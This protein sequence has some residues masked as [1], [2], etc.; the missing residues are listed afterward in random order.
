MPFKVGDRV[1]KIR[2]NKDDAVKLHQTAIVIPDYQGHYSFC[3]EY[4][5]PSGQNDWVRA[6]PSKFVL[7]EVYNS[8]LYK[9]L[10]E[11]E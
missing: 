8:P 1:I 11:E 2:A 7:E 3:V 10:K 5:L 4:K 6:D 9:L